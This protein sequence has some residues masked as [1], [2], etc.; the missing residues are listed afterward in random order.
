MRNNLSPNQAQ[1]PFLTKPKQKLTV[2][3]DSP[4]LAL[5]RFTV[6]GFNALY[7]RV[8]ARKTGG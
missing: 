6:R 5:N 2:P 1:A 3:I 8:G 7:Y 4:A